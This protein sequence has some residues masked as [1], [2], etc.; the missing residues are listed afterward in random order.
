MAL[1]P[2][3]PM[4]ELTVPGYRTVVNVLPEDVLMHPH[5]WQ[6]WRPGDPVPYFQ[7][8]SAGNPRFVFSSVAGGYV[9]LMFT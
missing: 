3:L 5:G 1:R 9:M 4:T 2:P 8:P 7:A 6:S